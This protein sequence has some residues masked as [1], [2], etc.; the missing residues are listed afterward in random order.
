MGSGKNAHFAVNVPYFGSV[1]AVVADAVGE[2]P[3]ADILFLG[4]LNGLPGVLHV[5]GVIGLY[6]ELPGHRFSGALL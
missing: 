3:G 5:L 6:A 1:A 2:K 4:F